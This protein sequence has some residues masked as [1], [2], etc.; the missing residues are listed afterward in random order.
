MDIYKN[1]ARVFSRFALTRCIGLAC[2]AGERLSLTDISRFT[3]ISVA[4]LSKACT[5]VSSLSHDSL[6]KIVAFI[7]ANF[8]LHECQ[9]LFFDFLEHV[10]EFENDRIA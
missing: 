1:R 3:G 7:E 9:R 6:W 5:A 4:N 10:K 2:N 8:G